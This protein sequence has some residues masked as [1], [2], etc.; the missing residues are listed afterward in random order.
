MRFH[1]R[2]RVQNNKTMVISSRIIHTGNGYKLNLRSKGL[3]ANRHLLFS[4]FMVLLSLGVNTSRQCAEKFAEAD[5]F[6]RLCQSR[7]F[8][9]DN[10]KDVNGEDV[11]HLDLTFKL[12]VTQVRQ[13]SSVDQ[14]CLFASITDN[15]PPTTPLYA[16]KYHVDISPYSLQVS[17]S[18]ITHL[19]IAA[20]LVQQ[21][22]NSCGSQQPSTRAVCVCSL[23]PVCLPT[24][25]SPLVAI[26]ASW[27]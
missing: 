16:D 18:D 4:A 23:L 17:S 11:V 12:A 14:N 9:R 22:N 3:F 21:Y 15:H 6:S 5:T 7:K 10:Q 19:Q 1:H 13:N 2:R 25:A 20:T 26:K 27:L 8:P 24:A